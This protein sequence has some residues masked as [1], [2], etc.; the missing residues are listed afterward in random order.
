MTGRVAPGATRT[1]MVSLARSGR[2]STSLI[3]VV[4]VGSSQ[5]VCQMPEAGV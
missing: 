2:S 3:E 1:R 4:G 5:T